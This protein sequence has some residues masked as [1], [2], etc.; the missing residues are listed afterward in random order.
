MRLPQ[1]AGRIGQERLLSGLFLASGPS[2]PEHCS[3]RR[4]SKTVEG[5]SYNLLVA[6]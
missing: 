5:R 3:G 1:G 2:A 4:H 6:G